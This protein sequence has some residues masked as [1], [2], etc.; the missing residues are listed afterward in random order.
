LLELGKRFAR[1]EALHYEMRLPSLGGSVARRVTVTH[2]DGQEVSEVLWID[3]EI[4]DALEV[5]VKEAIQRAD[6]MGGAAGSRALLSL[7]L[8]EV[9]PL[10]TEALA[11]PQIASE[12]GVSD[13]SQ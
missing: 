8:N 6:A 1:V 9:I 12:R 2:P 7:L 10:E 3:S 13:G 11:T 5:I 4:A